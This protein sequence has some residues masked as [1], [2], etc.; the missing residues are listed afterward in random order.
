MNEKEYQK[1][2]KINFKD[3]VKVLILLFA[4]LMI[5]GILTYVIPAGRYDTVKSETGSTVI[6][7]DSFVFVENADRIPWYR[8]FIA[9]IECFLFDSSKGTI[10]QIC[11]LLLILGGCFKILEGCGFLQALV[12][13]L[14]VRFKNKRFLTICATTILVMLLSSFFGLFEE[15]LILFPV[16]LSFAVAMGW[17][18]MTALSLVLLSSCVGF[19]CALFNPFTI[20]LCSTLAGISLVD[21]LWYR[22]IMFVIMTAVVSIYLIHIAKKDEKAA[23]SKTEVYEQEISARE[24]KKAV[25]VSFL[26]L[27]VLVIVVLFSVIP[28]LADLGIGLIAMALAFVIGTVVLGITMPGKS[29]GL[30]GLFF[31]GVKNVSPS[32]LIVIT[33]FSIKYIVDKAGVLHTIFHYMSGILGNVSPYLGIVLILFFVLLIEFF[34]PSATAKASLLIPVLT[35]APIPG[36]SKT[37]IVF[38]YMLGDGYTNVFYPTSGTLLIGLGLANVSYFEWFKK[39]VWFQLLLLASSIVFLW[40]AIA[41]GL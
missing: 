9:P 7:P 30:A 32:I 26:F 22:V 40:T 21:G 15:L 3:M 37:V 18:R 6:D 19:T 13:L 36:I 4:L 12:K 24:R 17:S 8:W 23:G 10:Y 28:E 33:A 16:F 5:V 11:G 20:G 25:S 2:M 34:I 31:K 38:A 41:I 29:G 35:L 14:V 1:D 39:T 27:F